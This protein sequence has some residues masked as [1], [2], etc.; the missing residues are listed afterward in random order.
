MKTRVIAKTVA[1]VAGLAAMGLTGCAANKEAVKET[2]K[3][4]QPAAETAAKPPVAPVVEKKRV[5]LPA[6]VEARVNGTDIKSDEI[7]Q[8][9]KAMVARAPKQGPAPLSPEIVEQIRDNAIEQLINAELLYQAGLKLDI[10]DLDKKLEEEF[11]TETKRFQS[12]DAMDQALKSANMDEAGLR[13][14]LKKRYVVNNLLEKQVVSTITVTDEEIS[15]FYER[16]KDKFKRPESV[17]AS[18]ILIDTKPTDTPEVKQKAKEK[19]QGLLKQLKEGKDFA[20]L[21]QTESACPSK[22]QG[23]DLNFFGKGQ[24]VP[25]FENAAFALKPGEMSDVVE[26]QFGYHIIKVTEKKP[27]ETV[28][29]EEV[30][31]RIKQYLTEEKSQKAVM[32]SVAALRKDAVVVYSGPEAK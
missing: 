11:A 24:M 31:D 10:P 13:L 8:L 32:D 27:E 12:K 6:G 16:N 4:E 2:A 14:L 21:A 17:R 19:A 15:I 20:E 3:T 22:A 7:N 9:T 26:T 1:M 30:K 5:P 18:H 29:L 25:E 28:P 23:G